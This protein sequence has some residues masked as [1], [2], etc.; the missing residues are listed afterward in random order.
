M[1]NS[2]KAFLLQ[3]AIVLKLIAVMSLQINYCILQLL[4]F[5][6]T[7]VKLKSIHFCSLQQHLL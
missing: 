7:L 6:V 2:G 3:L 4:D 1:R 5:D